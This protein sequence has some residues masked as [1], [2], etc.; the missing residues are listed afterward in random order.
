MR[1]SAP[2]CLLVP[3][4]ACACQSA[5]VRNPPASDPVQP[6]AVERA[7]ADL[8]G[9]D[10][11]PGFDPLR[12]PLAVFDGQR[13]YLFR[14]PQPPAGYV[15]LAAHPG[16]FVRDGRDPAVIANTNAELGGVQTATLMLDGGLSPASPA[17]LAAVAAHESFHAYQRT[18]HPGWAGNEADLFAYP[19]EDARRLAL[20]REESA[21]LRHALDAASPGERDCWIRGAMASRTARFDGLAREF[22]A[23]E[24]GSELNEGLATY[25][26]QRAQDAR[27]IALDARDFPANAI[28]QRAYASGAAIALLLDRSRPDWRQSLERDDQQALDAMLAAAVGAGRTCMP[29]PAQRAAIAEQAHRDINA[30]AQERATRQQAFAA[31]PGWRL[32]ILAAPNAPLWPQGFDPLNVERLDAARILHSRFVKLGNDAGTVEVLGKPAVTLAAGEHPLFQGLQRIEI[33]GMDKPAL[34]VDGAQVSMSSDGLTLQ[35]GAAT[36]RWEGQTAVIQ[37]QGPR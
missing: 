16:A 26:Q 20:R 9:R 15:A 21:G 30:L 14:H 23:Y 18:H 2:L 5:H 17:S 37:L 25:V 3:L 27:D 33:A 13:T 36:L 22:A 11:W 24:R 35:F 32:Q 8:G 12:V 19:V 6:L 10:L 7:M 1:P 31:M 29:D 28:R 4:L 34:R